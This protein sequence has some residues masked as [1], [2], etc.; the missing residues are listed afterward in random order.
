[1]Q[2]QDLAKPVDQ[3]TDDELMAHL[4]RIRENRMTERPAAKARA[5]RGAKKESRAKV[6]KVDKMVNGMSEADRLALIELL[7]GGG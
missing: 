7:K 1:M 3:M 4:R 6:S 5:A 2:L